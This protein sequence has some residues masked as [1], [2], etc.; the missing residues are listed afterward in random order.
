MSLTENQVN[1]I[2]GQ[3]QNQAIELIKVGLQTGEVNL[4]AF[5]ESDEFAKTYERAVEIL[6]N[7]NKGQHQRF[8][9]NQKPKEEVKQEQPKKELS[10]NQKA[11]PKCQKPMPLTWKYHKECGWKGE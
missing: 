9:Y 1:I 10:P 3:S 4:Q 7:K 2:L 11:C 5:L 6:F 8:V